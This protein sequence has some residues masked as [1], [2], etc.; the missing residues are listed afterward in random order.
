M[1]A[2]PVR[3]VPHPHGHPLLPDAISV[4]KENQ[5]VYVLF[6]IGALITSTSCFTLNVQ[7]N[8]LTNLMVRDAERALVHNILLLQRGADTIGD[9]LF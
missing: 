9:M 4:G 5:D 2:V 7:F 6:A 1:V 8:K 3:L